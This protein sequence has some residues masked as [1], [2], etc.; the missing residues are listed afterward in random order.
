MIQSPVQLYLDL[1]ISIDRLTIHGII[2][3]KE[4]KILQEKLT[5]KTGLK[6]ESKLKNQ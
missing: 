5:E 6:Y 1:S 3:L 2:D 4:S